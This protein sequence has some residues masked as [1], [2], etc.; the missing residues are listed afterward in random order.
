[1]CGIIS[2]IKNDDEDKYMVQRVIRDVMVG[3]NH[4]NCIVEATSEWN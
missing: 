4:T 1:M 3:A 2:K